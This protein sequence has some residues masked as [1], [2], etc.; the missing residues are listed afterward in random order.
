MANILYLDDEAAIALLMRRLLEASGHRVSAH[1]S[2]FEALA[3]FQKDFASFDL[4]LTDLSIPGTNGFEFARQ[5]QA[6][7]PGIPVAIASGYIDPH[8]VETARAQG[9]L[10]IVP[11]P[12]T[13]E[14]MS[15]T[16]AG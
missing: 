6:I 14:E 3:A 5:V 7:K 15:R 13:V 2:A 1:T 8:D 12:S 10:D 11:K 9:L 4:V 16:I